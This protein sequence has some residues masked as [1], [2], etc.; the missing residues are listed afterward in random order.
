[1]NWTNQGGS[2]F[3]CLGWSRDM[4]FMENGMPVQVLL[5]ED[6]PER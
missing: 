6:S 2:S 1:M 4:N 5:V 3:L